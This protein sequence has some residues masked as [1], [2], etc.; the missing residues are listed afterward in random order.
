[1][2]TTTQILARELGQPEEYV[3]NVIGLLDE[4]NTIPFIARYRKELH[5]SMDDTTLRTLEDRLQYLRNLEKRREE[6]KNA[7]AGQEKLTEELAAAIDA[8]A[9]LAE[10]EDL[11]RPYRPKRR[12][13]ATMAKEK[14]LEPLAAVLF[15]QE[16][17]CPD[18]LEA[19]AEYVDPEKGVETAEDA[20]QGANDIIAEQISDDAN[21]RKML[22]EMM[23]EK[24]ELETSAAKEEDSVYRLYY[25]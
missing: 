16:K 15:A 3:Q 20:L 17:D 4:G 9:T 18:P 11:Y 12:T 8:A 10:V 23:L 2:E 7:I 19:A 5:G 14:G 25:D 1:M 24:S 6:V 22:R 21:I 13:R